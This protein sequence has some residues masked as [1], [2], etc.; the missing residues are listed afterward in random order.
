MTV[1]VIL[2]WRSG[3][4]FLPAYL[5]FVVLF[6]PGL[7]LRFVVTTPEWDFETYVAAH[8]VWIAY[9]WLVAIGTLTFKRLFLSDTGIIKSVLA[10]SDSW[11]VASFWL[12]IAFKL[13][14][15]AMYGVQA[16][17]TYSW[18][19]G[20]SDKLFRFSP[21][22][23]AIDHYVSGFAVGATVAYVVKA[24]L[25]PRYWMRLPVLISLLLYAGPFLVALESPI[26]SRR[27]VLILALVAVIV[28]W[29]AG[30]ISLMQMRTKHWAMLA[31]M[32]A[33]SV[34]IAAYY[35]AVR[36]NYFSPTVSYY[37]TSNRAADVLQGAVMA[38]IPQSGE[39]GDGED[40]EFFR[41]GP[42]EL[43]Y[44]VIDRFQRG[45]STTE[46]E[47]ARASIAA[48]VPR[49]FVGEEKVVVNADDIIAERLG[50]YP[51]AEYITLDLPTSLPA[52]GLAEMGLLGVFA[53][54][55]FALLGFAV[56]LWIARLKIVSGPPWMFFWLACV[57]HMAGAVETDL[58]LILSAV[59]DALLICPLALL[60]SVTAKSIRRIQEGSLGNGRTVV[61]PR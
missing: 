44:S 15:I 58:G 50:I 4:V 40:Q 45:R 28:A 18:I 55:M 6:V 59:R 61:R 30:R 25:I 11:I 13:Y 24:S 47:I 41:E 7:H 21:W 27:F 37:L 46:G 42:F 9:A 5:I 60:L 14:L 17:G 26:G 29:R 38:L 49:I 57:I 23:T 8:L 22:E 33:L 16:F 51:E 31:F 53:A 32:G 10:I 43:V 34:G 35:Q 19:A 3:A 20:V 48:I 2:I 1:P 54:P 52:I 12:W 56:I 39:G 36:N